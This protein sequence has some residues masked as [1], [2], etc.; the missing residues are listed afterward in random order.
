[1][2]VKKNRPYWTVEGGTMLERINN[3]R[4]DH[5]C[6]KQEPAKTNDE[7]KEDFQS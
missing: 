1:M 3:S 6:K 4:R 7:E 5:P 2:E